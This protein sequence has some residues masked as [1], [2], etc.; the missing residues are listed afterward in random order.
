MLH[1]FQDYDLLQK[2]IEFRKEKRNEAKKQQKQEAQQQGQYIASILK[3]EFH[4]NI[5]WYDTTIQQNAIIHTFHATKDLS[6]DFALLEYSFRQYASYH[7]IPQ[8]Y[9]FQKETPR[10]FTVTIKELESSHKTKQSGI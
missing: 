2:K 10:S 3:D 4:T 1:L 7:N 6:D 8:T 9:T 5:T